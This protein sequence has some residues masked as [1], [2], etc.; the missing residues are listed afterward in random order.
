MNLMNPIT[1]EQ[2]ALKY[3]HVCLFNIKISMI[4]EF[5]PEHGKMSLIQSY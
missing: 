3:T 4:H 5:G 1:N 2:V